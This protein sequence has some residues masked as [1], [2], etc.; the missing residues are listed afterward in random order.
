MIRITCHDLGHAVVA[1]QRLDR[2]VAENV[3]RQLANDLAALL[4]GQRSPV[5]RELLVYRSVD[6]VGEVVAVLLVELGAEL[7]DALVMDASLQLRVR[8]DRDDARRRGAVAVGRQGDDGAAVAL[9]R[10][11]IVQTHLSASPG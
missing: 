8:I 2:A 3:V 4:A 6:A 5:E 10:E 1:Q 11:A 7:G 9:F